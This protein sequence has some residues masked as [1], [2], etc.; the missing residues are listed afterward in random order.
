MI[1]VKDKDTGQTIGTITEEQLGFLFGELEEESADDRDYY[2]SRDELEVLQEDGADPA[3][4]AL[5][6]EAM[7]SRDGIEIEW[8][9]EPG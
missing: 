8:S 7:G 6:K 2:I 5:I 1:V 4:I 3:L 9:E